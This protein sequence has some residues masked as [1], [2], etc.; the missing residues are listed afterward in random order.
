M[1]DVTVTRLCDRTYSIYRGHVSQSHNL[2]AQYQASVQYIRNLHLS[3]P[4]KSGNPKRGPNFIAIGRCSEE[5][6]EQLG[7]I[8]SNETKGKRW[9]CKTCLGFMEPVWAD[10][11]LPDTEDIRNEYHDWMA[12]GGRSVRTALL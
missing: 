7:L 9:A 5:R 2:L 6:G 1:C 8:A 10:G 12:K 3:V 11:P 4:T